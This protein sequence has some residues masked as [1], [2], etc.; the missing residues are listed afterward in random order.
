MEGCP[1]S[2]SD[3][4][5]QFDGF[6]RPLAAVGR[7]EDRLVGVVDGVVS[8]T[9]GQHLPVGSVDDP[10]GGAAEDV[11]TEVPLT[12]APH[13]DQVVVVVLGVADDGVGGVALYHLRVYRDV[14]SLAALA[15]VRN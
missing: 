8:V 1:V 11:L 10:I 6:G 3:I 15:G 7:D 12:A 13:D 2:G 5:G 9:H 14:Q 4:T